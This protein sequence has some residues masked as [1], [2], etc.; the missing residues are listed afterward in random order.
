MDAQ[1]PGGA[2]EFDPA[3]Q[4]VFDPNTG[5]YELRLNP[6]ETSADDT[7]ELRRVPRSSSGD[8]AAG[9]EPR[10]RRR[11]AKREEKEEATGPVSRRKP[12][13]KKSKAKK[14]LYWGSGT[15]AFLLVGGSAAAYFV[16]QHLN[17]NISKVDVG[18]NNAAVS[19]GPMNILLIG[20]DRR[21]GKGNE[22]YGDAGSVGHADTT[23]LFHVSE[24]RSNATVLSIP[25][26]MITD[27]PDCRT[28]QEDGSFK[29]IPGESEVRF[30][31]SLGQ[32]GRDPGCTWQTVEKLTGLEIDHFMMADFNA[33]KE[34]SSAVGG[35]EVCLA[36]DVND[37]KSHLN[38]KKG[39]H[40]IEGEEALAFV[41]T[42]HTVGFGGD[43]DRIKLQQQFLS[44]LMRKMKSSGTLSSPGKLW[45]LAQTATKAL[46]VDT[47]IG[48]V[49]KLASL[50]KN[51]SKV[52][53]KNVTFATVPVVDNTDGA[54]VLL[55]KT[56]AEPLFAM[57]RQ[58]VSL[59]EVKEKEK[60]AKDKQAAL[61]KGPKADPADVR[62]KVL[63]GSGQFGAAQ[64]TV[65]W[66]Q[67]TE[68]MLRTSNGGNAPSE[69][70]KTTLE[71]AP[72]QAD[73]ARRL[74]DSM[75]LPASA[76]KQGTKDAE[77]MAEMTLTLGADFKG[78]GT[79]I[80]APSKAPKDIQ[81]VGA[82]DKNVCA[83]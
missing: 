74:A 70:K 24:D 29:N 12:K 35:V 82:D 78:A 10:G 61:L 51:L 53:L 48:T 38:L 75:G 9:S 16:Y 4:W 58:D 6:A 2:G 39:R 63:N 47:G 76:M 32:E 44:S 79:P 22:G 52:D 57:V 69:L 11:A 8:G 25:R 65:D 72:N 73:Q 41:R 56:K 23:L 43:L 68:G 62:V 81:R 21:D 20:T 3:D 5:N 77:P 50:G 17:S 54:T 83:K 67:N 45:G 34:M 19:D 55:D 59:T 7:T 60:A 46:T 14:A 66:M 1:G 26:D 42:R 80:S 36:K 18:E 15:L 30:N 49:S 64:E 40:T 13:P 28:K 37:P 71:Y 31:T 33:V 27:I